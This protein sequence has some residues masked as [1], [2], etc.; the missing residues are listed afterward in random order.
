MGNNRQDLGSTLLKHVEDTLNG[1]ETVGILLFADTFEKDG[2]VMVI[3][4]LHNIDLP[5]NLVLG[6]V[7]N[8]DGK[9]TTVVE[10]S[11]FG[12]QNC[13]RLAG[14]SNGLL[15][16]WLGNGFVKRESFSADTTTFL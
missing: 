9:V 8:G 5:E 4:Q 12:R 10:T 1:Q 11:E 15:G 14:T 3:V 13:A 16:N 6:S 7:L 2:Q